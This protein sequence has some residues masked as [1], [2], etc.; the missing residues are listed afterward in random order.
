MTIS[1]EVCFEVRPLDEHRRPFVSDLHLYVTSYSQKG[2][3]FLA[4]AAPCVINNIGRPIFGQINF[5]T[6]YLKVN[7]TNYGYQKDVET[8]VRKLVK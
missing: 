2:E 7:Q 8:T 1:Q 6:Y 4:W 5:N 3:S